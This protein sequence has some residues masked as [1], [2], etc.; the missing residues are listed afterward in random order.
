MHAIE[1]LQQQ[2]LNALSAQ[3]FQGEI[4]TDYATRTVLATDNS[5]YQRIPQAAVFPRSVVDMRLIGKLLGQDAYREVVIAARGGGTGTNGQSLTNSIVVDLSRHMNEIIEINV[6]ERWV[7]VQAGVVK[8]QLNA[9]LKPYGLFFSPELSTSNRATIGGMI[10]TDASGQGSCVYGKTRDHVLE[11]DTVLVGGDCLHSQPVSLKNAQQLSQKTDKEGDLYRSL[12]ELYHANEAAIKTTFPELNR[13]LTGYDL[14]HLSDAGKFNLNNIICGSEGTLGFVVEAKL[15]LLPIPQYTMLVNMR[16]ASF[17]GALD[18]AKRLINHQ[19]LSIE[20]ID[21]KVLQLAQKDSVWERVVEFFPAGDTLVQGIN[22]IEFSGESAEHV[23][24]EVSQFLAAI[25]HDNDKRIGYTLARGEAAVKRVYEMRKKA[26]GLLGNTDGEAR[27]QP[28]IEDMAV[29]PENLAAFISELRALLDSHHL[30]YGMFGH[31]DAGVLHVR[32]MLDMKDPA[33]SALIRPIT[34]AAVELV[35][36]YGGLLWGEHGKGLRSEYVP[37]FFGSLYPVIQQVKALFD[38]DNQLNPGKIATPT[39]LSATELLKIDQV[40]LRGEFDRQIPV[41]TWQ[42]YGAA[43][44]CNGNGAC[45]NYDLN[46]AMCP[47]WKATRQ[48]VHSPK[49]RASAMRE[50]IRLQQGQG[51]NLLALEQQDTKAGNWHKVLRFV[52]KKRRYNDNFNHEVY[53]AMSGCLACKSCVGQCPV[54]VNIP[55]LRSRFLQLYH[56]RYHR[57]VRDYLIASL[58]FSM[59]YLAKL[60]AVYNAIMQH[61]WSRRYIAKGLG[62]VDS[63]LFDDSHP[64]FRSVLKQFNVKMANSKVMGQLSDEQRKR[65]VILV[66]DCFTRFFDTSLLNDWIELITSLGFTIWLAKYQPNGKP[67][68][69]QGFRHAFASTARKNV[70]E[71]NTLAQLNIPFVGLDP[72]MTLVY[73]QEYK[74]VSDIAVV[75]EVLLPQEWLLE[76]LPESV[77]TQAVTHYQLLLHC[78]EKTNAPTSAAIW[79]TLFKRRGMALSMPEVGCCGMSGTYGHELRNLET[80]RTIFQ[81]SWEKR[82]AAE[83]EHEIL[84]TGY[85]CQTQVKRLKQRRLRHPIQ[86]LLESVKTQN[87]QR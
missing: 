80:S 24:T 7:R 28:F 12:Y 78:T 1:P 15:N 69:V 44:H 79:P 87:K 3:G 63:P 54:K 81:Q 11:L 59:P 21:S 31:V 9:F 50:W 74:A 38:P 46:D 26:V 30:D 49:G 73:R 13:C 23:E 71:L 35:S 67:L 18:D 37:Q 20:T 47:S 42:S 76:N 51:R 40:P 10:N 5:I 52:G 33:Q 68:H 43:M 36:R 25:T 45:Y 85:S 19:P 60:S 70:A 4:Q 55:D 8:D 77:D 48:R 14:A 56:Q 32:P 39:G 64:Q 57:P 27:P 6:S 2:F 58:E 53:D 61:R 75:P 62:M 22:L 34:D 83:D 41:A 66:Q 65:S 82:I 17:M 72:A 29:P 86:V 84:A 16:Y